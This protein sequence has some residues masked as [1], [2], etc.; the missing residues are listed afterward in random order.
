MVTEGVLMF[1]VYFFFWLF[2]IGV[3]CFGFFPFL[4][5]FC[6]SYPCVIVSQFVFSGFFGS[7]NLD[8]IIEVIFP[9]FLAPSNASARLCRED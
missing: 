9:S 2:V 5:F 3:F 6:N 8:E 7:F 1:V 4:C